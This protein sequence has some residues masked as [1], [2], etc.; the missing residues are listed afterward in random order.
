MEAVPKEATM[1][2]KILLITGATDTIGLATAKRL[3]SLW[4]KVLVHGRNPKKWRNVTETSCDIPG[5]A[6]RKEFGGH[7]Q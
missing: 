7:K 4:H 6:R 2:A 3:V 5:G 1:D